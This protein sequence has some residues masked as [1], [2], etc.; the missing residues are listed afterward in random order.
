MSGFVAE[1]RRVY[2]GL[3][4]VVLRSLVLIGAMGSIVAAQAAG[5]R[6]ALW[7][8]VLLSALAVVLALRP[9][10]SAGTVLLVG[11]AYVWSMT[12]EPL[13]PLVL[14]AAAGMVLAHQAAVIAAQGPPAMT[15]E[16]TQVL[17]T[18]RRGVMLWLAAVTVWGLALLADALP[19]GRLVYAV[20]LMLLLCL[21]VG[22]VAL[23]RPRR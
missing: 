1:R 2:P 21:A 4:Q 11:L 15:V 10:S 3:D 19:D 12:T 18:C 13:S 8:Q 5:A 14:A 6:P 9:E 17:R 20:G 23:L 16:P 22:A 7:G